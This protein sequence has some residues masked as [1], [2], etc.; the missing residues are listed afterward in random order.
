MYK[1][2][3]T[4]KLFHIKLNDE[5]MIEMIYYVINSQMDIFNNFL[6]MNYEHS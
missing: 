6:L 2:Y 3:C 1:T 4:K 5:T